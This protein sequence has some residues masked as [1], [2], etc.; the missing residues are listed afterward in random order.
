M[1]NATRLWLMLSA[2][3]LLLAGCTAGGMQA[4]TRTH[5]SATQCRDLTEIRNKA[6]V[7]RERSMSELAALEEA[8]YHPGWFFDPY[9]PA[10]L[11]VAQRRVDTWYLTECP[12]TR[13]G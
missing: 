7:T 12:Q 8:G 6:P 4:G 11:E 1:K 10:D 5:L 3:T 9:Y 13:P 2:L